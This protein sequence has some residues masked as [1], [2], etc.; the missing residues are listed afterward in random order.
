LKTFSRI[1]HKYFKNISPKA[2]KEQIGVARV[3]LFALDM[4]VAF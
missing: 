3:I 4:D 2:I 1:F